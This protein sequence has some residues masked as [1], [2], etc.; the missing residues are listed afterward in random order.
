MFQINKDDLSIY[1]TRGDTVA[2]SVSAS[3]ENDT[4]YTFTATDIIEIK[5]YGKK[6][7][8][9][10]VLQKR[11]SASEGATRIDVLLTSAETKIGE[12]I[13]KPT[14]YWYSVTL[15]PDTNPQT[16]IGY[17]DESG[18]KLFRL[19]P[20]GGDITEDITEE[21]IPVV[22]SLLSA[23]S[24]RPVQNQA[25]TRGL[26]NLRTELLTEM[27]EQIEE[28]R[29]DV[30]EE[31]WSA[32]EQAVSSGAITDIDSGFVSKVKE[33]NNQKAL[34][35]WVGTTEEYNAR[36]STVEDMFYILTDDTSESDINDAI[37]ENANSIDKLNEDIQTINDDLI[38]LKPVVLYDGEATLYA[39]LSNYTDDFQKFRVQ[40]YYGLSGTVGTSA[41]IEFDLID[42]LQAGTPGSNLECYKTIWTMGN[43]DDGRYD[44]FRTYNLRI[45]KSQG[46]LFASVGEEYCGRS[47]SNEAIRFSKIL[48]Y[49]N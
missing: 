16:I 34:R 17:D 12:I 46:V 45:Q 37:E 49:R 1:A 44:I 43:D 6:N 3:D 5:V 22:D 32:I 25:I 18:V 13:N 30:E 9:N 19:Y 8:D 7:C 20:E 2:F 41:Y 15:N 14:D 28:F 31:M 35:F 42:I 21:D 24:D 36:T 48:G 40:L 26:T 4:P 27:S 10:V 33:Q 23:T 11:F 39:E 47:Y 38:T 29:D